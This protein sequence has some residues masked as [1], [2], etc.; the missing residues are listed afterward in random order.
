MLIEVF[1]GPCDGR[2]LDLDEFPGEITL[3]IGLPPDFQLR[4]CDV[5]PPAELEPVF[6]RVGYRLTTRPG[7]HAG[8]VPVYVIAERYDWFVRAW[9]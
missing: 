7:T 8:R 1:G 4:S 3:P 2:V 6:R 5:H 9:A